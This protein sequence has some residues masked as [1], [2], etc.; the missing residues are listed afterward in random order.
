LI[1]YLSLIPMPSISLDGFSPLKRYENF[2]LWLALGLA[3]EGMGMGQGAGGDQGD[4]GD[5]LITNSQFPM[6]NSQC[7]ITVPQLEYK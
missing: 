3:I 5:E 6:P 2:Y 1:E 4:Q 7:P